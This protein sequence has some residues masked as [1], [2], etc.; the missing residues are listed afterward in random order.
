M[1]NTHSHTKI[2]LKLSAPIIIYKDVQQA[3][4]LACFLFNIT[5]EHAIRKSGIQTRGT[6][7][8]KSVQ[9]M[10]YAV[11]IVIIGRSLS[12]TKEAF[13][14]LEEASKEVGLVVNKGET[15]YLVAAN[16]QNCSKPHAIEIRRYDFEKVDS[17]TYLGSLVTGNNNTSE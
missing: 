6:K 9:I 3:G 5:M 4:T 10:A 14:L 17:F 12:S 2:P 16:T 15:K 7:H 8:Y 11:D 1:S 13:Q